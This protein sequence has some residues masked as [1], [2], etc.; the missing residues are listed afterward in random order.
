MFR[1]S[2]DQ[3][4][5]SHGLTVRNRQNR[6]SACDT[7]Y[8]RQERPER[9]HALTC[10]DEKTYYS[11]ITFMADEVSQALDKYRKSYMLEEFATPVWMRSMQR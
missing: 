2:L 11:K 8:G 10:E 1:F 4:F 7:G 6:Q 3:R 9:H 5:F